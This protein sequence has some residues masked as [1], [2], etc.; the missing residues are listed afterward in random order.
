VSDPFTTTTR[1]QAIGRQGPDLVVGGTANRDV[2]TVAPGL[3]PGTVTV[4]L[5]GQLAGTFA[6]PSRS[7]LVY[8]GAGNDTVAVRGAGLTA[9]LDGG[10]GNDWLD[11]RGTGV[12]LLVGRAGNDTLLGGAGCDVLLGGAGR[13]SLR[14]S[15]GDDLLVGGLTAFDTDP[16]AVRAIAAEWGRKDSDYADRVRHL[17][18][19]AVG[20]LNGPYFLAAPTVG[21]DAAADR[22]VGALGRD[23][24]LLDRHDASD[25]GRTEVGT[26][27]L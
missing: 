24:F 26:R 19:S 16:T 27:L 23:W 11:G 8:G 17:D 14:G 2:I 18:G 1:I 12:S 15:A 6:R 13:D 4:R 7:V 21:A 20:G 22:L 3:T 25:C 5:N 9:Y 10:A